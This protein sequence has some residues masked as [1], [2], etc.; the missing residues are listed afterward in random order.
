ETRDLSTD[1]AHGDRLR[2]LT[3]ALE[4]WFAKRSTEA[5][6]GWGS[7]VDGTGQ[8]APVALQSR[9]EK[10]HDA[11]RRPRSTRHPADRLGRSRIRRPLCPR[12]P[13]RPHPEP[14]L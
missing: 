3:R 4:D 13:R 5:L 2:E 7:A 11:Q 14:R 6:D 9:Q 10:T 8:T 12:Q 1:P